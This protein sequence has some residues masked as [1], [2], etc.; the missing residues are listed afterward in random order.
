M[1]WTNSRW[2]SK[3][4][5]GPR[6]TPFMREPSGSLLPVDSDHVNPDIHRCSESAPKASASA[7]MLLSFVA[8]KIYFVAPFCRSFSRTSLVQ[9]LKTAMCRGK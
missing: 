5:G 6:M 1:V 2:V 8:S 7:D 9:P 4:L 3:S